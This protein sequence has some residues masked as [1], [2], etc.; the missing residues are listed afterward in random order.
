[1]KKIITKTSE[2]AQTKSELSAKLASEVDEFMAKAGQVTFED[3]MSL[4]LFACYASA[5]FTVGDVQEAVFDFHKS[6]IHRLLQNFVGWNY[7]ERISDS[8]YRSTQY[9]KDIMNCHNGINP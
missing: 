3:Q 4:L 8:H 5:P 6:T 1:M 9:A 7:L 2:K